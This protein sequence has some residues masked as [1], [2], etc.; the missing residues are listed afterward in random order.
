MESFAKI[1]DKSLTVVF[2]VNGPTFPFSI[3][4]LFF[5]AH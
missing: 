2:S 5:L 3:K 1:E 4:K